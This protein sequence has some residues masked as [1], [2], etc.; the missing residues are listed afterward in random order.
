MLHMK[1]S[2][3][4]QMLTHLQTAY[5]LE[6]CGILGGPPG[7]ATHFYAVENILRSPT[8]YEMNPTVQIQVMISL[9]ER[10][11]DMVGIVHS[12]PA[13]PER[14]SPTDVAQAYYP[15]AVY[16]IVSLANRAQPVVKAFQIGDGRY[17]AVPLL[18]E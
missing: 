15:D 17:T 3:Y 1:Q 18:V 11:L 7:H 2:V 5:P 12:H 16:V 8:A 9:E 14:P 4:E 6:G 13:G 10:G